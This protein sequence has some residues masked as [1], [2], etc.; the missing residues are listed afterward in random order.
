MLLGTRKHTVGDVRIYF[1]DY[2]QGLRRGDWITTANITCPSPDVVI[3][4]II[5]Q[6]GHVIQFTLSGGVLNEAFT[7][8]VQ[9]MDNNTE[10]S[11]DTLHFNVV[12]P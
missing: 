7:V 11:N 3:S 9:A 6:E 10:L 1:V 8:T 4:N 2:W 12:G 5:I